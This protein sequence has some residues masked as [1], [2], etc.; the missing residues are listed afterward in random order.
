MDKKQGNT[1]GIKK[2]RVI[3]KQG[4]G[5]FR[6]EP[7]LDKTLGKAIKIICLTGTIRFSNL[8]G[9]A[10]INRKT[11]ENQRDN[12]AQNEFGERVESFHICGICSLAV[13][14]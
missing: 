1:S 10:N 3:A 6:I 9:T 14:V 5:L 2:N 12:N 8:L 13:L 7:I 11:T 4:F